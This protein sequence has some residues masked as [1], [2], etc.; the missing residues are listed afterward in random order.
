M[1][2]SW[3]TRMGVAALPS[4]PPSEEAML[5]IRHVVIESAILIDSFAAPYGS[6]IIAG[7]KNNVSGANPISW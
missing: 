6:V 5:A 3:N 1:K 2:K 7:L 4:A